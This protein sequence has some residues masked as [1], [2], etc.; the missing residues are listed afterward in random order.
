[1]DW[2]Q[3]AELYIPLIATGL[4]LL[5][6]LTRLRYQATSSASSW[7]WA[8]AMVFMPWLAVPAYLLLG[9]RKV[10]ARQRRKQPLQFPSAEA[11][12]RPCSRVDRLIQ[13]YNLPAASTGNQ[14]RFYS[15]EN[16]GLRALVDLLAGATRQID[17][18]VYI[19]RADGIGQRVVELLTAKAKAGVKVRVLVDGMGSWLLSNSALRQL[20]QHGGEFA[21]FHPLLKSLITG[22][23][24]LR[25]H[26]KLVVIDQ[27]SAWTGGA[28]LAQE[29]F[30]KLRKQKPW[31]D[32]VAVVHGPAVS[33]L[34]SIFASDWQYATGEQTVLAT[35]AE[36]G[37]DASNLGGTRDVAVIQ[38]L[39]SGPDVEDEPLLDA[40]LTA[41]YN[42]EHQITILTP[43]FV[44][45][46]SVLFALESALRRGVKVKIILPRKSDNPMV[47]AARK[48]PLTRLLKQGL[49]LRAIHGRMMHAKAMIVDGQMALIGSAN[50]DYRSFFIN[51]ELSLVLHDRA[52]VAALQT[53]FD[54]TCAQAQDWPTLRP[55]GPLTASLLHL[56]KP[57]L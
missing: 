34:A 44:P 35:T 52:S 8:L 48:P 21:V 30:A 46:D 13:A 27:R 33:E 20:R 14:I 4:L 10:A 54:E 7:G 45:D 38:V 29:Y 25:N 6:G 17:I 32:L 5:I 41:I 22:R 3:F 50:F 28:N 15:S 23:G 55:L 39:P 56:V 12:C 9:S 57:L 43:Y 37:N 40:V 24:G 47:D 42:A 16:G 19:L 53:W 26:R 51:Y 2:R 31:R 36:S 1:M 11:S 49:N 18:S